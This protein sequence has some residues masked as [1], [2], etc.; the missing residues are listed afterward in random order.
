M[1]LRE[2]LS[3]VNKEDIEFPEDSETWQW[4]LQIEHLESLQLRLS[5]GD[6][7]VQGL[8]VRLGV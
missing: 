7:Q 5:G 1:V 4:S 2:S 3:G 8:Y 6:A